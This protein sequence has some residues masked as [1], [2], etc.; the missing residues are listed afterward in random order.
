MTFR[1]YMLGMLNGVGIVGYWGVCTL[2]FG[3]DCFA[4]GFYCI[5]SV[6]R[7]DDSLP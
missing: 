3:V 6:Y 1:L 5:Y 7:E 2:G 4:A